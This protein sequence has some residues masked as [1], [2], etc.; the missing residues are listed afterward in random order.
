M[1]IV[2]IRRYACGYACCLPFT[3]LQ[4]DIYYNNFWMSFHIC[5]S[6]PFLFMATHNIAVQI[7]CNLLLTITTGTI[8][9]LAHIFLFIGKINF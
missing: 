7:Y 5:V 3:I 6:L 9:I 8:S 2:Y 4:L 1:C